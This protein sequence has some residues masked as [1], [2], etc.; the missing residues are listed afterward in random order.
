M[1]IVAFEY[2]GVTYALTEAEVEAAYRYKEK[3]Y[4]LQD[5][6]NHIDGF[7]FGAD[8]ES[9]DESEAAEAEAQFEKQ[10]GIS[11]SQ[12]RESF[13]LVYEYFVDL[14]DCNEA[15]NGTWETAVQQVVKQL[16]DK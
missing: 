3:Q 5:A 12:L 9:L 8:P 1:S 4:R 6:K 16:T 7:I 10:Y 13:D 2:H 14:F 15:E 11:C